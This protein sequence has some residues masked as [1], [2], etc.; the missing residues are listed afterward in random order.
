MTSNIMTKKNRMLLDLIVLLFVQHQSI[1]LSM[2]KEK[3][4]WENQVLVHVDLFDDILFF[5]VEERK[6]NVDDD[7]QDYLD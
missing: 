5:V 4:S 2:M 6:K 7:I 1:W 3:I